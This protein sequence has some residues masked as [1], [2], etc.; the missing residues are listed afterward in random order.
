[1]KKASKHIPA[2]PVTPNWRSML[3]AIPRHNREATV[4]IGTPDQSLSIT[5]KRRRT[6]WLVPPLSW[7]LRPAPVK[8]IQLDALGTRIWHWCDGQRTVEAV[9]DLFAHEYRFT[10]HEARAAVTAYL[11]SLVQRGVLALEVELRS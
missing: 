1:M 5:V 2:V 10:F 4:V 7:I 9:V 6:R 8:T 11:R 3:A